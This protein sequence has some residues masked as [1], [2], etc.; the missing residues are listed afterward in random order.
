MGPSTFRSTYS[1]PSDCANN[2]CT[3]GRETSNRARLTCRRAEQTNAVSETTGPSFTPP[4]WI[5]CPRPSR[6]GRPYTQ[7]PAGNDECLQW[8]QFASKR[9]CFGLAGPCASCCRRG[10]SPA[11]ASQARGVS[12]NVL[13]VCETI[14]AAPA[15]P[16]L[17]ANDATQTRMGSFG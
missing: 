5:V 17:E 1:R 9:D 4:A 10:E 3:G 7:Q 8:D 14:N 13:S 12:T 16:I 6:R 2:S 15:L 11:I